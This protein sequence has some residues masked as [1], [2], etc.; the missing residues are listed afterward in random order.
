MVEEIK[1]EIKAKIAKLE[2][3][4]KEAVMDHD[5]EFAMELKDKIVGLEMAQEIIERVW[6][7]TEERGKSMK[8]GYVKDLVETGAG[9]TTATVK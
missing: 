8:V 4:R 7:H 2:S 9:L 3:E 6:Q 1:K 5:F